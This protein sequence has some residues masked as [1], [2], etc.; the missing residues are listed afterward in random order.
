MPPPVA[1]VPQVVVDTGNC[2]PRYLRLS[3]HAAPSSTDLAASSGMPFCCLLQPLALPG[4]GEAPVAV[5]N[6][7]AEGPMRCTGCKAYMCAFHRWTEGGRAFVCALCGTR[8]DCRGDDVAP[9]AADGSRVDAAH[10]PEFTQGSVEYV[11]GDAYSVRAPMQPSYLFLIDCSAAALASGFTASACDA[12]KRCLAACAG[13]ERARAGIVAMDAAIRFFRFTQPGE[14]P[15]Q[16]LVADVQEPH[17]ATPAAAG[18]LVPLALHLSDL[19][20]LCDALPQLV[21]ASSRG[22]ES[23]YSAGIRAAIDALCEKGGRLLA[24]CASQPSLGWGAPLASAVEGEALRV[25]CSDRA[26]SRMASEA[27]ERQVCCDLF[28]AGAAAEGCVPGTLGSLACGTGGGVYSYPGFSPALDYAQLCNDVRW[29]V[30]RPQALEA[31]ARLRVPTGATVASYSGSYA[32]RTADDVDL[33]CLD[34]DKALM[35]TLHV[36]DRKQDGAPFVLQLALLY[37]TPEGQRRIRVHSLCVPVAGSLAALFRA[38]DMDTQLAF[39]VR[40]AAQDMLK[41]S[42]KLSSSAMRER[43]TSEAVTALHA[44][45]R[46]CASNSAA[47]QLILPEALKLLPLHTL[48]CLKCTGVR[49]TASEAERSLWAHRVL[50]QPAAAVVP[51]LHARLINL[52]ECDAL[53]SEQE[54]A[55]TSLPPM[56]WLSSER[57][58]P[59][60]ICLV[61]DG[62]TALLHIGARAQHT[63]IT[64]LFGC[65]A[66]SVT[67]ASQLPQLRTR[68]SRALHALLNA[69]RKQRGAYLRLRVVRRPDPSAEAPFFAMMVE[70]RN[71]SGMSYVEFLCHIHRLIQARYT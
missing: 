19:E 60:A 57:L 31:V 50:S 67:S 66:E 35:A 56:L 17:C 4:A 26:Y 20:A 52:A 41:V 27:A 16:L 71:T 24:F 25:G 68:E 37:S 64:A 13:G 30:S 9:L 11:A 10:R 6:P 33:P 3:T 62:A 51:A 69:V 65:P 47:G 42:N 45:R 63:H 55:L 58:D 22:G 40:Q 15:L 44:Y 36:E 48:G 18:L 49:A 7:G 38:A 5:V 59:E 28:L 32:S 39:C 12:A 34:C 53:F 46:F 23:A 29:N 43:I 2:S 14:P 1:G 21:G 70:D 54:E 8:N 61:E